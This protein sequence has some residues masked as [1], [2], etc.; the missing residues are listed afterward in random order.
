MEE[1]D[2]W[3]ERDGGSCSAVLERANGKLEV[4]FEPEK[5]ALMVE[6]HSEMALADLGDLAV[7]NPAWLTLIYRFPNEEPYKVIDMPLLI[8]QCAIACVTSTVLELISGDRLQ[9]TTQLV[10][11][12]QLGVNE[13][14]LR[15]TVDYVEVDRS[16]RLEF[17][18]KLTTNPMDPIFDIRVHRL[19]VGPTHLR[20]PY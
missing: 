15:S 2:D 1:I 4:L 11:E 13:E 5:G 14:Y 12:A 10:H 18:G 9:E 17:E 8:A 16:K 7:P 6:A 3:R 20:G 19:W